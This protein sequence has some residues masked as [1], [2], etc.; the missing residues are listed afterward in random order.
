MSP[1]GTSRSAGIARLR[2]LLWEDRKT[3]PCSEHYW[4]WCCGRRPLCGI[5]AP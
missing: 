2:L 1:I 4:F 3:F 5:K